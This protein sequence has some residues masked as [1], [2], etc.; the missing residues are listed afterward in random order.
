M[1]GIFFGT[2]G[3]CGGGEKGW[4]LQ[5]EEKKEEDMLGIKYTDRDKVDLLIECLWF[6]REARAIEAGGW[7]RE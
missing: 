7:R 6:R 2:G 1:K 5:R 4:P 3:A